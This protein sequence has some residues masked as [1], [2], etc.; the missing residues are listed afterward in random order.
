VLREVAWALAYAHGHTSSIA[1]SSAENILL[2][3][4]TERAI[5][6]DFGIASAMQTA[7][8]DATGQVMGNAH[9]VSPEQAAGEPVERT[10]R[11]LLARHRR[12]LR[13]YW[14]L[15][16]DGETSAEVVAQHLTTY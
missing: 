6:M 13:T 1:T 8:L 10:Q 4:G 16:F 11:S 7:A 15:P 3:R 9:Y 14:P 2:E 12:L 5:V